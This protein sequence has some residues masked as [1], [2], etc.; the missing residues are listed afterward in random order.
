[1][2]KYMPLSLPS[3]E[4][5][6]VWGAALLHEASIT[7]YLMDELHFVKGVTLWAVCQIGGKAAEVR[8]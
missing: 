2:N 1:M 8:Q 4:G 7:M 5:K 6:T 3:H